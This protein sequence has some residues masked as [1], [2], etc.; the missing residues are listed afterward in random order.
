MVTD[1]E[2]ISGMGHYFFTQNEYLNARNRSHFVGPSALPAL[3]ARSFCER[4]I[5]KDRRFFRQP[6]NRNGKTRGVVGGPCGSVD[7]INAALS[8]PEF[9]GSAVKSVN[10]A[11][12][13]QLRSE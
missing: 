4:P 11:S 3:P 10:E 6:L 13:C 12:F 8:R 9:S 1:Q 2:Q 7:S 5:R